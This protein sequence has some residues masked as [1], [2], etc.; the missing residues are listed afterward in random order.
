MC[1]AHALHIQITKH[2]SLDSHQTQ[3]ILHLGSVQQIWGDDGLSSVLN[4]TID[5]FFREVSVYHRLILHVLLS[6][7]IFRDLILDIEWQ[8]WGFQLS[9]SIS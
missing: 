2:K 3:S 8:S 6:I 4:F 1:N 9:K 5:H 7:E